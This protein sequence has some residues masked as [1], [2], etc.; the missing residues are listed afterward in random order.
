MKVWPR[1]S[2]FIYAIV[3]MLAPFVGACDS[4]NGVSSGDPT[5]TLKIIGT[6][7]ESAG[8]SVAGK[9]ET[10]AINFTAAFLGLGKIELKE[11][12]ENDLVAPD[13]AESEDGEYNFFGSYVV[14]LLSGTS[15]PTF[16][17]VPIE[18]GLYSKVEMEMMPV[19]EDG[20]SI[21]IEGVWT[22]PGGMEVPLRFSYEQTEDF[23]VED[24]D[25]FEI[26]DSGLSILLILV[27]LEMWFGDIDL[28][29]ADVGG[30]GTIYLNKDSNRD[31]ADL[32]ETRLNA[33]SKLGLDQNG[34]GEIDQ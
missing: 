8:E 18:P 26:A 9:Q 4:N 5:V 28:S 16:G 2:L 25:G 11:L 1:Q 24:P 21:L 7:A 23:K 19:L 30:D 34:D 3:M 22:K 31:L 29:S 32:I 17:E 13:S 12:G 6:A 14:D 20:R 27:D 15:E 10:N 33:A